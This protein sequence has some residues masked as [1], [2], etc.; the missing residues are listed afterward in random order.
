M[1]TNINLAS[2]PYED[3]RQFYLSWIP[4][5]VG[6]VALALALTGKAYKNFS[7]SRRAERE[8]SSIHDKMVE[9]DKQRGEATRT[10]ALPENAGTRDAAIFLNNV[11]A[12]KSFSWT[13][14]LQDLEEATPR[15]VQV[16]A[17]KPQVTQDNDLEFVI[18]VNSA[19]RENA[20]ELVRRLERSPHFIQAHVREESAKEDTNG[21]PLKYK[22]DIVALY[23]ANAR[24]AAEAEHAP[25]GGAR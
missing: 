10:L 12:R 4:L 16:T 18:T 23:N 25:A 17:I 20:I 19:Q 15:H 24:A 11:F 22:V 5:I 6:L 14:I 21:G 2:Q 9:L 8:I 13:A 1:R 3:A 7:D